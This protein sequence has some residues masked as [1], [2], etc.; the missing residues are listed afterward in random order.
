MNLF[1][2]PWKLIPN[3]VRGAGG[4]EIDKLRGID[5]PVDDAGGSEAWIG[6]VTRA[7]MDVPGQDLNTGC[8]EVLLPDGRR[9]FLYQAI[10]LKPEAVLGKA[11]MDL[12]GENLGMLIKYLDAKEPYLLQAHPTRAYAKKMWD[13]AFGKEES[14]YVIGLRED[15]P[16]PPYILLGFKEGVTRADME[17]GYHRDDLTALEGLCHKI[18]VRVGDTYFV[19]GGVPHAL[20]AGCFVIEV[21]EPS[22]ITV[23]PVRLPTL[24][25]MFAGAHPPEENAPSE[26]E[27]TPEEIALYDERTLGSFIYDGCSE[28]ENLKRRRIPHKTIRKGSWGSET[29]LIGPEQTSYFSFSRLDGSGTA[30]LL[31]TGFPR[32]A[33]VLSGQGTLFFEGG[34]LPI[35]RGDE[36]FLPYRIPDARITGD[37]SVVLCH[38]EGS[39]NLV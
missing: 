23:V 29:Y 24:R 10:S 4:R 37:F 16:E 11:H 15:V 31:D 35:H 26:P 1:H 19:G 14:W 38:P 17:C 8:A 5:P 33:I 25:S 34:S 36:L 13:S 7:G 22:D 27:I 12:H 21:Q 3:R 2:Q 20:G 39:P 30:V 28:E 32:V 18:P 9:M 6:S